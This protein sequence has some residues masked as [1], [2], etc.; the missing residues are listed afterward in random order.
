MR[1][2]CW[3][4]FACPNPRIPVPLT[5][6]SV[7]ASRDVRVVEG[8]Q[9][10]YISIFEHLQR[11]NVTR[12]KANI[13]DHVT[14]DFHT[15]RII[16]H[17]VSRRFQFEF[18]EFFNFPSFSPCEKYGIGTSCVTYGGYKNTQTVKSHGP[19][20][21]STLVQLRIGREKRTRVFYI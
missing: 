10:G 19:N 20:G 6:A 15:T 18:N 2:D 1:T 5:P 13:H 21:E 12:A 17:S 8:V 14:R 11:A 9:S 16:P 7:T 4:F 3:P